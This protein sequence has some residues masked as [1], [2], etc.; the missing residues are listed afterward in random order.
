MSHAAD[1]EE[2]CVR[3]ESGAAGRDRSTDVCGRGTAPVLHV[4]EA[5]PAVADRTYC[6]A[7]PASYASAEDAGK[8]GQTSS[9]LPQTA[10]F[11]RSPVL[12]LLGK[13]RLPPEP[14]VK[15]GFALKSEISGEVAAPVRQWQ[16]EMVTA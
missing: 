3:N 6:P 8:C 7:A 14:F 16:G 4:D 12:S 10:P 9:F 1:M 11:R 2:Q 5:K 13:V 15:A